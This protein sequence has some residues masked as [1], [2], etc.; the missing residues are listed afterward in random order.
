MAQGEW[1]MKKQFTLVELLVVVAI[2]GILASLLLPALSRS[3]SEARRVKCLGQ[4][5]QL[6]KGLLMYSDDQRNFFPYESAA[7][8]HAT[9]ANCLVENSDKVYSTYIADKNVF[10][11]PFRG[12]DT[13]PM[14]WSPAVGGYD[15]RISYQYHAW[16]GYS[17]SPKR[18]TDKGNWVLMTDLNDLQ[19]LQ[20]N[21]LNG[22]VWAGA[23]TLYTDAHVAWR[24]AA[25]ITRSYTCNMSTYYF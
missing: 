3:L 17:Q 23:N 7:W 16:R 21:H 25:A 13:E 8:G 6:G 9:F 14:R 22:A 12:P 11:C 15:T 1:I 18:N 5:G 4:L 19:Q 24:H 20:V 10:Y 2:I